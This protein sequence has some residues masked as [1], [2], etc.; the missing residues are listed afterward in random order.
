MYD[1]VHKRYFVLQFDY[2]HIFLNQETVQL[3]DT[4]T[5]FNR[6]RIGQDV[7]LFTARVVLPLNAPGSYPST[8]V[9]S[10]ARVKRDIVLLWHLDNG[11]GLY[12]YRYL[13]S[14]QRYVGV[15]AQEVALIRP[16]AVVHGLD[17][18]LRVDYASLGL[19]LQTWKE[20]TAQ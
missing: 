6:S 8:V 4:A 10:D 3:G 18:Y 15:M 7:D 2:E 1:E 12:R 5:V 13:W 11:L 20:W 17:G 14:D 16:D 19:R 9:L